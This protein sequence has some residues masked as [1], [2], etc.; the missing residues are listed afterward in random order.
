MYL[1]WNDAF[2]LY[3][4]YIWFWLKIIMLCLSEVSFNFTAPIS[5]FSIFE[6]GGAHVQYKELFSNLLQA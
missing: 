3:F 2:Q 6:K 1:F 5:N 4:N